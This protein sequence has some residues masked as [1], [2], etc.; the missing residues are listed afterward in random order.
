MGGL[1]TVVP[2]TTHIGAVY[3]ATIT[4]KTRTIVSTVIATI[5]LI[6]VASHI[7]EVVGGDHWH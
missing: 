5:E 1:L 7:I 4:T 2:V 6:V 3:L